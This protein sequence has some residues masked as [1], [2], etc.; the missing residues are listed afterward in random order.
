MGFR[1]GTGV[2]FW[3]NIV[4][5]RSLT[6]QVTI[7]IPQGLGLSALSVQA[8][9]PCAVAPRLHRVGGT[10]S[11]TR[12]TFLTESTLIRHDEQKTPLQ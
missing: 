4:H 3:R 10:A 6:C 8:Y 9:D 5:G 2:P 1:V 7:I 12:F 11:E